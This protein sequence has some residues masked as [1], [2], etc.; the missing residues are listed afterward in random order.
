[1]TDSLAS[2]HRCVDRIRCNWPQFLE[3]RTQ[4]LKEQERFGSVAEKV[5]EN[6]LEDLFTAVLDWSV[7]DVNHQV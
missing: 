6:I 5:A 2:Y 3:K 1:M 7:S 4:R